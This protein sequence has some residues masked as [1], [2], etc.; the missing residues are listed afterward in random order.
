V[1]GWIGG[2]AATKAAAPRNAV[3]QSGAYFDPREGAR[4]AL[5]PGI[6]LWGRSCQYS[7]AISRRVSKRCARS[8]PAR[9]PVAALWNAMNLETS[10]LHAC[11]IT[12]RQPGDSAAQQ[13]G[14]FRENPRGPNGHSIE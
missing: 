14:A 10:P 5:K 7:A 12:A 3:R 13:S 6:A 4:P 1:T 9:R 8:S 2:Q 11:S